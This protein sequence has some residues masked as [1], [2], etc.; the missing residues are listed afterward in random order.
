MLRNQ[1]IKRV[2]DL[3]E[4]YGLRSVTMDDISNEMGISKKTLYKYFANRSELVNAFIEHSYDSLY[5]EMQSIPMNDTITQLTQ[6]D[7][8]LVDKA[9]SMNPTT[10]NDLKRYYLD[11]ENLWLRNRENLIAFIV[12][13]MDK[14]KKTNIFRKELNSQVIVESRFHQIEFI[15]QEIYVKSKNTILMEQAQLFDHFLYGIS[16]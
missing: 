1:I 8:L 4:K 9:L 10:L 5:I 16:K 12:N 3:Y 14:E 2:S 11:S 15:W 13:I 6:V 7:Q